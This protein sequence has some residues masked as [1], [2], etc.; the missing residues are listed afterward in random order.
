M[1]YITLNAWMEDQSDQ[2]ISKRAR[3]DHVASDHQ[4]LWYLLDVKC[5]CVCV[6]VGGEG[7]GETGRARV[8]PPYLRPVVE[9]LSGIFRN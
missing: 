7:G 1:P 8:L 9:I 3:V 6:G 4:W 2:T 5:L